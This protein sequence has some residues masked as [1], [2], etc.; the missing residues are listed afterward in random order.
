MSDSYCIQIKPSFCGTCWKVW[1]TVRVQG[2]WTVA[3][4]EAPVLCPG[5]GNP[6]SCKGSHYLLRETPRADESDLE[7]SITFVKKAAVD[8]GNIPYGYDW[9]PAKD[10]CRLFAAR[11]KEPA[12]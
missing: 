12:R 6:L 2:N 8:M 3:S 1:A 9:Q 11:L 10:A 4:V 7:D 5:C